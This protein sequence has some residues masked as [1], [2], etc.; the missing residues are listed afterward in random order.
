MLF[1]FSLIIASIFAL[2]AKSTIKR[3]PYHFLYHYFLFQGICQRLSLSFLIYFAAVPF[4]AHSGVLSCGQAPSLTVLGWLSDLCQCAVSF[5]SLPQCWRL[6]TTLAMEELISCV[7]LLMHPH[8]LPINLLPA[9]LQLFFLSL[10]FCLLSFLFQR[11]VSVWKQKSGS[12]S[13]ALLT[14]FTRCSTSTLCYYLFRLPKM[15]RMA[16][17][18]L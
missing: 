12:R 17:I 5:P 2:T 16:T 1:I 8:F 10:W 4:H 11:F 13:S 6:V 9:S 7:S 3:H 15:A 18:F 14:Y